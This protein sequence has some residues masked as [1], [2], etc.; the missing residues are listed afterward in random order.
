VV[1]LQEHANQ[2][3]ISAFINTLEQAQSAE[4]IK[5]VQLIPEP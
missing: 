2:E 3:R 5:G 1:L 4:P